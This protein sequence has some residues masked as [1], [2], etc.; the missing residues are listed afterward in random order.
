MLR[1]FAS[2]SVLL[3]VI[4]PSLTAQPLSDTLLFEQ[5]TYSLLKSHQDDF[6]HVGFYRSP[7]D[8]GLVTIRITDDGQR[9]LYS[10]TNG[11][12]RYL[13]T[14]NGRTT[15]LAPTAD[16]WFRM[17][18]KEKQPLILDKALYRVAAQNY[19][20]QSTSN[21]TSHSNFVVA[22]NVVT[23]SFI[24]D[25]QA[26]SQMLEAG[27]RWGLSPEL[28]IQAS[29]D[30]ANLTLLNSGITEF[31]VALGDIV[32]RQQWADSG[33]FGKYRSGDNDVLNVGMAAATGRGKADRVVLLAPTNMMG[34]FLGS[35]KRWEFN[36]AEPSQGALFSQFYERTLKIGAGVLPTDVVTHELGHTFGLGHERYLQS[37]AP[38]YAIPYG[39]TDPSVSSAT[40]MSYGRECTDYCR[41]QLDLFSTP[42]Y[43]HE[44]APMG[45]DSSHTDA[46]NAAHFI[47]QTWPLTTN[48]TVTVGSFAQTPKAGMNTTLSWSLPEG[49]VEQ[50]L[51][52]RSNN[53]PAR[54]TPF[55]QNNSSL[56]L[57]SGFTEIALT[58][59]ATSYTL[60]SLSPRN[61]AILLGYHMYNGAKLAVPLAMSEISAS[62][63]SSHTIDHS[64][65]VWAV[66][67]PGDE[68][69]FTLLVSDTTAANEDLSFLLKDKSSYGYRGVWSYVA[70][71]DGYFAGLI[72]PTV[73]GSGNERQVTLKFS[74]DLADYGKLVQVLNLGYLESGRL[75]L[76]IE[77]DGA[78]TIVNFNIRELLAGLPTI[79]LQQAEAVFAYNDTG[80][81]T[82]SAI[83][84]GVASAGEIQVEGYTLDQSSAW[85]PVAHSITE[86]SPGRF[87]VTADVT[88]PAPTGDQHAVRISIPALG[89]DQYANVFTQ[90]W[91]DVVP[92]QASYFGLVNEPITLE[93]TVANLPE[94]TTASQLEQTSV[95]YSGDNASYL[96]NE[97]SWVR[98]NPHTAEF[99][100]TVVF[101][102][103]GTMQLALYNSDLS[104]N[105]NELASITIVNPEDDFDGDGVVN[106]T[107]AFPQDASE[108][109]DS[110]GDGTGNNADT[111]DDNDGMSDAFEALYSLDSLDASDAN[112]DDDGDGLTN[113]QE[114]EL[115]TDPTKIDS[116]GDGVTD[117]YD[118]MPNDDAEGKD[119]FADLDNNDIEDWLLA[120]TQTSSNFSF[121]DAGSGSH[122]QSFVPPTWL[123][124]D[125][126]NGVP[127]VT[128][129]GEWDVIV[130]GA[131]NAGN[132][133]WQL[134]NGRTAVLT[135]TVMYP[136]WLYVTAHQAIK[137]GADVNGNGSND[138][139]QLL[140][141]ADGRYTL[142]V[143]DGK[144]RSIIK[145]VRLPGWFTASDV[146]FVADWTGNQAGEIVVTGETSAGAAIWLKY[147]SLDGRYLGQGQ[148]P[149][150]FVPQQVVVGPD[151]NRNGTPSILTL[152][153]TQ[154]GAKLWL[155]QDARSGQSV[156]MAGY[157]GWLN[158]QQIMIAADNA[159]DGVDDIMTIA[160]TA[161][162]TKLWRRNDA[163][164]GA[165]QQQRAYPGWFTPADYHM[166]ADMNGNGT[167]EVITV[168]STA[169]A[170]AVIEV[171]DSISGAA[172]GLHPLEQ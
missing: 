112:N 165:L 127:D 5:R 79:T 145:A 20:D 126:I 105:A 132:P 46:A 73:T 51:F 55:S 30:R 65:Q 149:G 92:G 47:K 123:S 29:L 113:L 19:A 156:K 147:D 97:K 142:V 10:S 83:V 26:H 151:F 40:T 33:E 150:W 78:S 75:E 81:K 11:N 143:S 157:P 32:Y 54:P 129:D 50:K 88:A 124:V 154:G 36:Q 70:I 66:T 110:D 39:Y 96:R 170:P 133:V 9:L 28:Q 90:T 80:T 12:S 111:D 49:I 138:L 43:V 45:R 134:Y 148:Y 172:L 95:Y 52:T 60:E 171:R 67:A 121:F 117:Y 162:G 6:G 64:D 166:A 102:Y 7:H 94:E 8:S 74:D 71:N 18:E 137:V 23:V 59:E 63:Y 158:P 163:L 68:V 160:E 76:K 141:R 104:I 139:A 107:D 15:T 69:N 37:E 91:I 125:S 57:E 159:G 136:S 167:A 89:I 135:D 16:E 115:S 84:D 62:N 164:T 100:D 116:D 21:E 14:K 119:R 114:F 99:S 61:C 13:L 168:G 146:H 34:F 130:T 42:D 101:D 120:T 122:T 85:Q 35:A 17:H 131:T 56:E 169:A 87:L 103:A 140:T 144:D 31:S 98:V 109:L 58:L 38:D 48:T 25:Y 2:I 161:A 72:T 4:A 155:A 41:S 108:W 106:A 153:A 3:S 77:L 22:D 27:E 118:A 82:I 128:G 44:G 152:G 24:V 93:G 1:R 53:C 86:Q